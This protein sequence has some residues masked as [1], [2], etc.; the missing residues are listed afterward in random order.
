MAETLTRFNTTIPSVGE[1]PWTLNTALQTI[2]TKSAILDKANTYTATNTF[3]GAIAINGATS[4]T[5]IT[6]TGEANKLFKFGAE[7]NTIPFATK[8]KATNASALDVQNA[9][10][11]SVFKVNTDGQSISYL[12]VPKKITKTTVS[13]PSSTVTNVFD[14][15]T[16]TSNGIYYIVVGFGNS[17]EVTPTSYKSGI[18]VAVSR[19]HGEYT[20]IG[21][22]SSTTGGSRSDIRLTGSFIQY[23][24]TTPDTQ[25]VRVLVTDIL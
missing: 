13:V 21:Q 8:I 10:G 20:L 12:D 1:K 19:L 2:D 7:A 6:T 3:S 15:S 5:A 23:R 22:T 25:L 17:L 9:G 18:L 4:G 11:T 16:L 24:Q 14:L